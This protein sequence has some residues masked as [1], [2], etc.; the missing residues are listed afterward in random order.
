[1]QAQEG[2]LAKRDF[3]DE[4]GTC[5]KISD[6]LSRIG[7]KWTVL[8]VS[9]LGERQMR[10]SELRNTI[11]NISQKMLTATLRKLERDGFVT[12]TVTPSRPPRVDYALTELGRDL[13]VPVQA[14]ADWSVKNADRIEQARARFEQDRA[15]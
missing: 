1:M 7:D 6:M 2:T 12:R 10:F 5:H 4:T 9:Y 14:L 11:G 8:I 3:C 13:L 15:G